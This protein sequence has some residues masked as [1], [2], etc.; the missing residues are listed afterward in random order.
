MR[1]I[2]II[3]TLVSIYATDE[4]T[5]PLPVDA[6]RALDIF[7]AAETK[8]KTEY[9]AKI[10]TERAK[11]IKALEAAKTAA[12]RAGKLEDALA[13]RSLLEKTSADPSKPNDPKAAGQSTQLSQSITLESLKG[14]LGEKA[15]TMIQ[16]SLSRNQHESPVGWRYILENHGDNPQVISATITYLETKAT[17]DE[18]DKYN[19]AIIFKY[20]SAQSLRHQR[21]SNAA[22]VILGRGTPLSEYDGLSLMD[23]ANSFGANDKG[24]RDAC[25][26]YLGKPLHRS[27]VGIKCIE[28]L[29]SFRGSEKD[30]V[31]VMK[32]LGSDKSLPEEER[33]A[34]LEWLKDRG[35]KK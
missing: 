28:Y 8:A 16:I 32:S 24:V 20:F 26:K 13:I 27:S 12:T 21:I 33:N 2:L 10:A 17:D 22:A 9:D 34:A 35:I 3:I 25:V 30:V 6:Q 29:T 31:D 5:F 23:W 11:M 1:H 14:R 7:S 19:R 18:P 4:N 15:D